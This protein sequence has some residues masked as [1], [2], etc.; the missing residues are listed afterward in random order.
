MN[1][2]VIVTQV[3]VVKRQ[4]LGDSEQ[5]DRDLPN[6]GGFMANGQKLAKLQ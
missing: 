2:S 5:G 1:I 4:T 6:G 3:L